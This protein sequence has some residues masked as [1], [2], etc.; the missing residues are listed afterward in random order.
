MAGIGF[1][2]RKLMQSGGFYGMLRAYGFAGLISSG[3]WVFSIFG[4]MLIGILA[5]GHVE[6]RAVVQ[7]LVSV[8]Y[9]MAGSLILTGVLQLL[10]SRFCADRLFEGKRELIVPNLLGT[11][12]I[13][14]IAAA[15]TG[16]G[17][18][19]FLFNS[20][21]L[22]YR[23][24]MLASFVL[25]CDL[26]IV[27]VLLSGLKAYEAVLGLFFGGYGLSV[28]VALA[29]T[30][31]GIVGLLGGFL[32]GQ[33]VMFFSMLT[34]LI[35][36]YPAG[37]QLV[38]YD[39]LDRRKVFISLAFTGLFY[40]IGI[41]V[42]KFLFWMNP[43]TSEHVIGPLRSSVIYDMPIFIAYLSI[44]PGM[45][46]FLVRVETDFAEQYDAFYTAVREGDTLAHIEYLRDR[47]VFA[48]RQGIY[49]IFK[50]QGMTVVVLLLVGPS[51]LKLIGISLVYLRL[52]YVDLVGVG[53]Q[54][55]LLAI[56]NVFFYLDQRAIAF[57][58]TL[59]FTVANTL[60]TV[61][62]QQ[63]G[64]PFYGYGFAVSVSLTSA[65]GLLLLSRK[66]ERLEY[67]TFM[68]QK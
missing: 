18:L 4:V 42:D 27:V 62:T 39:F 53:M 15:V 13:T 17:I 12:T 28:C 6:A 49:E 43:A 32:V 31:W 1:E 7:F 59:F 5:A 58:L 24:A 37:R 46:V 23:L 45:A 20:E 56:L 47:M 64:A 38:A 3:P 54:V 35:R 48:V 63:L 34:L 50:V 55:L 33:A 41:W 60:L 68:L 51:L 26:W 10:F 61:L 67:E 11:L 30:R 14:S 22:V 16:F 8:T 29:L 40:N 65:L 66:L 19:A 25:L 44:V 36:N 52:F 57:G 2:L 9:L 21:P